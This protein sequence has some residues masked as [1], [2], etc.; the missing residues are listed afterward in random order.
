[1]PWCERC[2]KFWNPNSMPP[3]GHCPKCEDL[4]ATPQDELDAVKAPWH[5]WVLVVLAVV[6]L[7]WRTLQLVGILT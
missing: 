4:I 3:T 6:Y 5:F 2:S 7:A 1:M